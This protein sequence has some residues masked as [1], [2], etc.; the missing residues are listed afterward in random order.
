MRGG[1]FLEDENDEAGGV[2]VG[3][4]LKGSLVAAFPVAE[5]GSAPSPV[6]ML[7]AEEIG[8]QV[9]ALIGCEE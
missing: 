3:S 9:A 5:V 4:V 1:G 8:D 6:G 7:E 2:A